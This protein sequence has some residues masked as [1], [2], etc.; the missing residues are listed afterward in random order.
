MIT[1]K[2][3]KNSHRG[4]LQ[5]LLAKHLAALAI[6][7]VSQAVFFVAN[8][9]FFPIDD[10][11]E[12]LGILVGN[13]LF[14]MAAIGTILLPHTILSLL[15]SPKSAWTRANNIMLYL[16]PVSLIV[17]ANGCDTSYFPF[18][19]RRLSSEIFA[20]LGISGQMGSLIPH[21]I[22]DFPYAV[23][24]IVVLVASLVAY[25]IVLQRKNISAT[26]HGTRKR[27]HAMTFLLADILVC[28]LGLL[29]ISPL[30]NTSLYCHAQNSATITNSTWNILHTCI[31]A[32]PSDKHYMPYKAATKIYSPI[33]M[34]SPISD[35]DRELFAWPGCDSGKSN[36]VI[37]VLESFSQ[38]YMGCYNNGR[39]ESYTPFLDSIS[40]H[41]ILFQGRANG[42]K[43][44]EGI[45]AI[46]GSIP[47]LAYKPYAESRFAEYPTDQM[48]FVLK[49]NGY[50]TA[51]FHG[52]YNGTMGF[53]TYCRHAGFDEYLGQ[54]EY[55]QYPE[56]QTDAYDGAW[57]IYDE[58]FLQY[59]FKKID[60]MKE[61]FFAGIFT[62]SS[63]HPFSIPD[64]YQGRLK[65][66]PHPILPLVSYTDMALK[67]FFQ[68][69]K[70]CSWY[71]HTLF[72]I[73]AD[74]PGPSVSKEFFS[75][76]NRYKIPM[77]FYLPGSGTD[78]QGKGVFDNRIVQQIDIM[79]S[80]LDYLG[81]DGPRVCFGQS[82]FMPNR[83]QFHIV[84]GNG[85]YQ[86]TQ[87]G[88]TVILNN[89]KTE[90]EGNDRLLKSIVQQYGQRMIHNQLCIR[91]NSQ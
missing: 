46:M 1:R 87:G 90:G 26:S 4:L 67:K 88:K 35:T 16:V 41:S 83:D 53:D 17:I 55:E 15:L 79:P 86:L 7:I 81:I 19:Y 22:A 2:H 5:Q 12:Y 78:T 37:I 50:S 68:E 45:P 24:S 66:G 31:E 52:G 58:P 76:E 48:P 89:G 6:L 71:Q 44:I 33:F 73:T 30:S 8:R 23:V 39:W 77:I 85:Y 56:A 21:F 25:S 54:D 63:H 57:G 59:A 82:L 14:G 69:A 75:Q 29:P 20:Y 32:C 61:P 91:R 3:R 34:R 42:K 62:I 49:Q 40:D 10:A 13:L 60:S 47:T 51:F 65:E 70:A 64:Q 11:S 27:K 9:N 84:F 72:V 18:T 80:I 38:E 74:H 43:S 28:A 36:V